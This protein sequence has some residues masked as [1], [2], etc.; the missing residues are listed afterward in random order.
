MKLAIT[1]DHGGVALKKALLEAFPDIEWEDIGVQNPDVSVDYPDCAYKLAERIESG[2][3]EKAVAV[4][5]SGIGISMALNRSKKVRAAVVNEP[6][7]AKLTRIDNDAN[8]IC[9]GA[10]LIGPL[11][12]IE[13]LKVFLGTEFG[14]G[15]HG[16]R[17]E[18]L[19]RN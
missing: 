10:R 16:P 4:C 12:A 18:K 1:N 15:R 14:G 9:F 19:G 3:I 2:E 13:C 8:V 11:M 17:V 6:V 7:S 5:G